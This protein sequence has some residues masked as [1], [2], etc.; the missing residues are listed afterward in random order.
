M[1]GY[2]PSAILKRNAK[3]QLF[4][5][6]GTGSGAFLLRVVCAFIV[7]LLLSEIPVDTMNLIIIYFLITVLEEIFEAILLAGDNYVALSIATN[8]NPRVSD[9]FMG[10][11]GNIKKIAQ[12]R[13]IPAVLKTAVFVPFMLSYRQYVYYMENTF[14][15]EKMMTLYMQADVNGLMELMEPVILEGTLATIITLMTGF[16]FLY[17]IVAVVINII[18][19]QTLFMMWDYPDKSAT[20]ILKHS[21]NVMKN[22]WGRYLYL[23]LSFILWNALAFATFFIS[24]LWVEPYKRVTYANFYLD[25]MKNMD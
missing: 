16:F 8:S 23:Q 5:Y 14:D 17:I 21:I 24:A 11:R 1:Y 10:F 25:L 2:L 15:M 22:S 6:L 18:F 4:R 19:S 20:V 7:S 13:I 3:E 12:L 9:V